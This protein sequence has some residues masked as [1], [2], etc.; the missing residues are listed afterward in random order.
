MIVPL[1][2]KTT[3]MALEMKSTIEENLTVWFMDGEGESRNKPVKVFMM[4]KFEELDESSKKKL[5]P[6][7]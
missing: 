6:F 3:K 5:T 2:E 1:R 7:S 4:D